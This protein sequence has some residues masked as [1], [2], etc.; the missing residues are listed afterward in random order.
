MHGYEGELFFFLQ[1]MEG[2]WKV[3]S[4][5]E[6]VEAHLS[7]VPPSLA[8]FS[9]Y[10]QFSPQHPPRSLLV[11]GSALPPLFADEAC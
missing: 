6:K 4:K 2:G 8:P 9:D 11:P 10:L 5:N 7:L 3:K 1:Q